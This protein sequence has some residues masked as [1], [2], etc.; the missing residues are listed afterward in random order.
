MA[1]LPQLTPQHTHGDQ[2]IDRHQVFAHLLSPVDDDGHGRRSLSANESPTLAQLHEAIP[3]W[4]HQPDRQRPFAD[5]G[6]GTL[7]AIHEELHHPVDR[8]DVQ[9]AADVDA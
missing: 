9:E 2:P 7:L 5:L 6:S 4:R 8:H 1:D 3:H